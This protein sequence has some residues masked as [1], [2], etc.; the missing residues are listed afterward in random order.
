[1]T[2]ASVTEP[3]LYSDHRAIS[4]KLRVMKR[5]KKKTECRQK[6]INL[7]HTKLS[8]PNIRK[9]FCQEVMNNVGPSSQQTYT[10]LAGAVETATLA[11]LPKK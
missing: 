1:M 7:D 11:S 3:I 8:D 2:D 5:L 4:L 6:I 9:C 10:E